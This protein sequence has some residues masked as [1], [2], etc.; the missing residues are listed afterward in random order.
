MFQDST[1]ISSSDIRKSSHGPTGAI[2]CR[3]D[4]KHEGADILRS[5]VINRDR[6]LKEYRFWLERLVVKSS[7]S[8]CRDCWSKLEHDLLKGKFDKHPSGCL[9]FITK[10]D[11]CL[12]PENVHIDF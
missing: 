8:S 3:S 10:R 4:S 11:A 12:N 6:G 9:R 5:T 7:V 1:L 2:F